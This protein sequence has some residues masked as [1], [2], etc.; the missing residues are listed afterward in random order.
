MMMIMIIIIIMEGECLE[1][2][3]GACAGSLSGA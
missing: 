1:E 3:G 2:V